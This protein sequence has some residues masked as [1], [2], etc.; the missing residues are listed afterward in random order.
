MWGAGDRRDASGVIIKMRESA[1]PVAQLVGASAQVLKGLGFGAQ[2]GHR[3]RLWA[4]S[5]L[6]RVQKKKKRQ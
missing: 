6:V 1:A 3:P 2:A 5:Q 4:Q